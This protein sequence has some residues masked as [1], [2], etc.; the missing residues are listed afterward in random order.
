MF[1]FSSKKAA[2]ASAYLLGR[3]DAPM[4]YMKLIKLL[5]LADRT[6]L[7]RF[8]API[9]GDAYFAMKFGPVLSE[10][11]NL[12]KGDS[13]DSYWSRYI[14]RRSK[15]LVERR[16]NPGVGELS[17]AEIGI[18]EETWQQYNKLS[19]FELAELTHRICPEWV[20]PQGSGRKPIKH[21]DILRCSGRTDAEIREIERDRRAYDA[22]IDLL[23]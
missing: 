18:L 14:H 8:E 2:Q 7:M 5:Y 6:S 22:V 17:P 19:Q 15:F 9:T 4:N 21:R 23:K 1:S 11:L 3:A 20:E 13:D 10:T 16:K 12:L